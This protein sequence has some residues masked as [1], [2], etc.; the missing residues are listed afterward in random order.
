MKISAEKLADIIEE[1]LEHV[2]LEEGWRDRFKKLKRGAGAAALAGT[3][4]AS[5]ASAFADVTDEPQISDKEEGSWDPAPL[6][7]NEPELP[8]GLPTFM[9]GPEDE[10][11]KTSKGEKEEESPPARLSLGEGYKTLEVLGRD[12]Q[13]KASEIFGG[14]SDE[15]KA[16]LAIALAIGGTEVFGKGKKVEKV[17]DFYDLMGG[18]NNE[19]RGFAQFNTRYY[20]DD[21]IGSPEKYATLLGKMITGKRAFPNGKFRFNAAKKLVADIKSGEVG[22]GG[23]FVRWLKSNRFGRSNWQGIDD[24]WGRV[25]RLGDQLVDFIKGETDVKRRNDKN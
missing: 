22:D 19:M 16:A 13:S 5:P 18:T 15:K 17:D 10:E 2:L 12:L 20:G 25:P 1:E 7:Y 8:S 11:K 21:Q 23:D 4:A 14:D 24:G 9:S 3:L 6:D